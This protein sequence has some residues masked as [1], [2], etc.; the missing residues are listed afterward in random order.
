MNFYDGDYCNFS[1]KR[2][3]GKKAGLLL[4]TFC[5]VWDSSLAINVPFPPLVGLKNS[6]L[7]IHCSITFERSKEHFK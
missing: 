6:V 4:P 5:C 7:F 3:G 1:W 2:K